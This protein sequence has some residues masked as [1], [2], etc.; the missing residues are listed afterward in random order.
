MQVARLFNE[1]AQIVPEDADVHKCSCNIGL[2]T[3]T[4]SEAQS[5]S[6]MGEYGNQLSQPASH[7][8]SPRVSDKGGIRTDIK[9]Y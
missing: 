6:S 5:C 9:F 8:Q 4:G 2:S 1:A 3:G 7:K